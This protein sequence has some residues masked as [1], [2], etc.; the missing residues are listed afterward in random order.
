MTTSQHLDFRPE[1]GRPWTDGQ[2]T[3]SKSC[4]FWALCPY[5][6]LYGFP[7]ASSSR[8]GLCSTSLLLWTHQ[9]QR[10]G[11]SGKQSPRILNEKCDAQTALRNKLMAFFLRKQRLR[12]LRILKGL[13]IFLVIISVEGG[14]C[15]TI[16]SSIPNNIWFSFYVFLN[17]LLLMKSSSR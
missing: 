14:I 10:E 12:L 5:W 13:P 17:Q 16:W 9:A 1:M 8:D 4:S 2:G 15:Y 7:L 11:V 3:H 6:T